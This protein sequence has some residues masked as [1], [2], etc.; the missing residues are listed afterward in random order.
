MYVCM[1][2]CTSVPIINY[3][4]SATVPFSECVFPVLGVCTGSEAAI[5]SHVQVCVYRYECI[6]VIVCCVCSLCLIYNCCI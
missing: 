3:T 6:C 1:Y 2:L 4:L 5:G